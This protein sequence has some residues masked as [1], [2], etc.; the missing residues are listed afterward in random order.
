MGRDVA[1]AC[2][3]MYHPWIYNVDKSGHQYYVETTRPTAGRQPRHYH[4]T[5]TPT[6]N[7]V[8]LNVVPPV[9]RLPLETCGVAV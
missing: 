6:T 1:K 7:S 3:T 9:P 8:E 5:V 4:R 2:T